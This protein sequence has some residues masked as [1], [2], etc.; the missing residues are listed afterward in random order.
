MIKRLSQAISAALVYNIF[1]SFRPVE[2]VKI[3]PTMVVPQAS[4]IT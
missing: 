2:V 1:N 4:A 3:V